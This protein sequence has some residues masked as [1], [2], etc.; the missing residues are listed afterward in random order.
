MGF[1]SLSAAA[2]HLTEPPSPFIFATLHQFPEVAMQCAV[3]KEANI[4]L[5]VMFLSFISR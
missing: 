4:T 5:P 3:S 1:T 2:I